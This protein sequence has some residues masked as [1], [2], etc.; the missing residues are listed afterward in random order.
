MFSNGY[1]SRI[2]SPRE[3]GVTSKGKLK[4]L[5]KDVKGMLSYVDVLI[6]DGP[7]KAVKKNS[8]KM[9]AI[10]SSA[11]I[12]T[13]TK[14]TD[15]NTNDKVDRYIY[16]DS[17]PKGTNK[18]LLFSIFYDVEN[19]NPLSLLD[20][21]NADNNCRE[22]ELLEREEDGDEKYNKGHV[23]ISEIE[24]IHPCMFK[25]NTNIITKKKCREKFSSFN[26]HGITDYNSIAFWLITTMFI[27]ILLAK[28]YK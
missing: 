28:T 24:D 10:G 8:K 9:N 15:T 26:L 1:S 19:L 4:Y 25:D 5:V 12:N 16:M 3:M 11:L 22:V 6:D 23:N 27:Y 2:K 20:N 17:I 14:C 7:W 21:L 13:S 18:S